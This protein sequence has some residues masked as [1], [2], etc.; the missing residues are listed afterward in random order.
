[1]LVN[2]HNANTEFEKGKTLKKSFSQFIAG[3]FNLFFNSKLE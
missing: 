1:M 3:E 2:L